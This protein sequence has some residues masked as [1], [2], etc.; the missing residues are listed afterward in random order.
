MRQATSKS[1]DFAQLLA[2]TPGLGHV[3]DNVQWLGDTKLRV[4]LGAVDA[5]NA[6][7]VSQ[8][9]VGFLSVAL[10]PLGQLQSADLT[11]PFTDDSGVL[12]GSWGDH[13]APQLVSVTAA[14]GTPPSE[15][16]AAN[17]VLTLVWDKQTSTPAATTKS[18]IDAFVTFSTN[19]GDYAGVWQADLRTLVVT[20]SSVTSGDAVLAESRVG[21]MTATMPAV[22][23]VLSADQSSPPAVGMRTL[24]GTWGDHTPPQLQTAVATDAGNAPGL[25]NGDTLVITFNKATN[26]PPVAT[27]QQ[28]VQIIGFSANVG[29]LRSGTWTSYR[30]LTVTFDNVDGR[31]APQFVVPG[32]LNFTL[33]ASSGLR[34]A[35]ESSGN[36]TGVYDI[37]GTFGPYPAPVVTSAEAANGG[38]QEGIGVGDTVTISFSTETNTPAASTLSTILSFLAETRGVSP[39]AVSFNWVTAQVLRVTLTDMTGA[40]PPHWTRI[41]LIAV[42]VAEVGA[43]GLRSA[44]GSSTATDSTGM[45]TGSWG[46][47]S[48]PQL[49]EVVAAD[50]SASA[51][52][53]NGDSMLLRFDRDTSIPSVLPL[54]AADRTDAAKL[55]AAV[56]AVIKVSSP[57]GA[58]YWATWETVRV[59]ALDVAHATRGSRTVRTTS[60]LGG[61][62]LFVGSAVRV[63]NFVSTITAP[64]NGTVM[65]LADAYPYPTS[66]SL[67][68]YATGRRELLVTITDTTGADLHATRVGGLRIA[69][70]QRANLVTSDL[71]SPP[72]VEE[73]TLSGT[74]GAHSQVAVLSVVAFDVDQ[75]PGASQTGGVSGLSDNDLLMVTFNQATNTPA[76]STKLLVDRMLNFSTPI[77]SD[78]VGTWLTSPLPGTATAVPGAMTIQ[79][80]S[81]L[82]GRVKSG[83]LLRV[84]LRIVQVSLTRVGFT[85]T[86]IPL[87]YPVPTSTVSLGTPG[88]S[89]RRAQGDGEAEEEEEDEEEWAEGGM[90]GVT[91][92]AA[93]DEVGAPLVAGAGSARSSRGRQLATS[94]TTQNIYEN[95][96]SQLMLVITDASGAGTV[97]D[98]APS[99][100]KV[101]V[102]FVKSADESSP[103]VSDIKTLTG[104]WN[105]A[106]QIVAAT[107]THGA[108]SQISHGLDSIDFLLVVFNID[109]NAPTISGRAAVDTT[110]AF[111]ATLG[112]DYTGEWLNPS[113][114]KITIIDPAGASGPAALR[115]GHFTISVLASAGVVAAEGN[116]GIAK[117][118]ATIRGL[119]GSEIPPELTS[120]T[121]VDGSNS[122]GLHSGDKI[123]FEFDRDTNTPDVAPTKEVQR[124][125]L[126]NTPVQEAQLVT[127]AQGLNGFFR[128]SLQLTPATAGTADTVVVESDD[129]ATNAVATTAEEV[130]G[131]FGTGLGES[132]Q[133]KLQAMADVGVV[134]VTRAT[135]SVDGSTQWQVVFESLWGDVPLMTVSHKAVTFANG[136][137]TLG[138]VVAVSSVRQGS[139]LAGSVRLGFNGATSEPIAAIADAGAVKAAVEALAGVGTVGV[140]QATTALGGEVTWDIEFQTAVGNQP[141]LDVALNGLTGVAPSISLSTPVQGVTS[142]GQLEAMFE[143]SSSLVE[144]VT[145]SWVTPRRLELTVHASPSDAVTAGLASIR[146]RVQESAQVLRSPGETVAARNHHGVDP[147]VGSIGGSGGLASVGS[148]GP[149]APPKIVSAA[150]ENTGQSAGIT[151]SD[152]LV[153]TFDVDTN[154]PAVS[155]TAAVDGVLATSAPLGCAYTGVWET[156]R[157]MRITITDDTCI[158]AA[159]TAIG[160]LRVWVLT[161]GD[162]RTA[163]RTSAASS[164]SATVWGGWGTEATPTVESAVQADSLLNP[165][166]GFSTGDTVRVTFSGRTTMPDVSTRANL[167]ALLYFH[168]TVGDAMRAS[169]LQAEWEWQAAAGTVALARDRRHLVLSSADTQRRLLPGTRVRVGRAAAIVAQ[170]STG[171]NPAVIARA[172]VKGQHV[173]SLIFVR[174]LTSCVY[175]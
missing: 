83:Q 90:D 156:A 29:T 52:L 143:F 109:T 131:A 54:A 142:R 88:T 19:F 17:D 172:Q 49:T 15:G 33:P 11:S 141:P 130:G 148:F 135:S 25:S 22:N 127:V 140:T 165:S 81:D 84:G 155:T 68:V 26:R 132:M 115:A 174:M 20:I 12:S 48:P 2:F 121:L 104:S 126:R 4:Q 21:F 171:P 75:E 116:S 58:A 149:R 122:P 14:D 5:A 34:S 102:N 56:D 89:R 67:A 157:R 36:V 114:A 7:P 145:A 53:A 150:A 168:S 8:T 60:A 97:A 106:P 77:G 105:P 10:K 124:V 23:S 96:P 163:D 59:G 133:S 6:L 134:T 138:N 93:M 71:T 63:G 91:Q 82:R 45:L 13:T 30:Q 160:V 9:R 70:R 173:W 99:K 18:E 147:I 107:A 85:A 117:G 40:D 95:N 159:A 152:S 41:G 151:A 112:T 79:T 166:P 42:K 158:G 137:S 31:A 50:T 139:T 37:T 108:V 111:S 80:S 123:V 3:I 169:Q 24:A 64:F 46:A 153:V 32:V 51:G 74:W 16:I 78:Y 161:T 44:D 101:G 120:V 47:R 61:S 57:L 62:L 87:Q 125:T 72:C 98:V 118:S 28:L 86:S 35:D 119:W 69:A 136:A 66:T 113:V 38:N 103:E 1:T 162:L 154:T 110:F 144:S 27:L 100:L 92:V 55:K 170:G 129:I 94:S 146:T 73:K 164:S 39:G 128:L 43:L 65:T 167:D 175:G 76:A